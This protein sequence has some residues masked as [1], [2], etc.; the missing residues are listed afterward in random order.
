[1]LFLV[2]ILAAAYGTTPAVVRMPAPPAKASHSCLPQGLTFAQQTNPIRGLR[3]LGDE[4]PASQYLAV[5]RRVGG[6]P[7]PAVVRTG[8]GR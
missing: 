2:A 1:M 4:P 3:R 5:E 6:C 8:I 7:A